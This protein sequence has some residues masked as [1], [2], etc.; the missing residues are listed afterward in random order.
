M[1]L[2]AI[3]LAALVC[4]SAPAQAAE[5]ARSAN[6]VVLDE[7]GVKNLRIETV[8][9]E[10][11]D[12]EETIFALGRIEAIPS[13]RAVVSQPH[14]RAA[15]SSSRRTLGDLVQA[16]AD[17]A[18]DR[19]PPAGRSAAERDA[20]SAAQRTRHRERRRA[21]ASRS[22]RTRRCM[23]ITDLSEVYAVARV[24]EHLAGKL[25]A[26]RGRAHPRRGAAGREVRR[27]RCCAS[28]PRPI[29]RAARSTP[30]SGCRIPSAHL[31][32]GM[33]AEFSI[34]LSKREGVVSVPRAALQGDARN[35]FV[36]VEDFDLPERLRED[37]GRRRRR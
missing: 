34:V 31:R 17:V 30:S 29:R 37:A 27:R 33:R 3:F 9:A 4:A 7:T 12:F 19:E 18:Q 5:A 24:P 15:S 25:Q 35:R 8:E 14:R 22:S 26:R 2:V 1:R 6:T 28:A 21:S 36:Y 11:T 20:E 13:K 16:G 10:E 32:P 23:E